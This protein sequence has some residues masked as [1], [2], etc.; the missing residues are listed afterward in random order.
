[1]Q[2]LPV[3]D[4]NLKLENQRAR[5]LRDDSVISAQ[6]SCRDQLQVITGSITTQCANTTQYCVLN[7]STVTN[8]SWGY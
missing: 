3:T 2:L 4:Y 6:I 8:L 5:Y 1:M 7:S